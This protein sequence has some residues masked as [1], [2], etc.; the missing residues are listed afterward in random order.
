MCALANLQ[1]EQLLTKEITKNADNIIDQI[2]QDCTT[3]ST[4]STL[5]F[6]YSDKIKYVGAVD[7]IPKQKCCGITSIISFTGD[8]LLILTVSLPR[9]VAEDIAKEFSGFELE[10]DSED[11]A[12][13]IGELA[14]LIAGDFVAQLEEAKVFVQMGLPTVIRGQDFELIQND[15]L[16]HR[17]FKFSI[18]AGELF[19]KLQ[20]GKDAHKESII[21]AFDKIGQSNFG[22]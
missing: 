22:C 4:I 3:G 11:M 12:D 17:T 21:P 14:N 1:T 7:E 13:F 10:F 5:S 2:Y 9:N 16:P 18:E 15:K 20:A 19:I 6:A 8:K